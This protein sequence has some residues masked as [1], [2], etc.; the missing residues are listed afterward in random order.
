ME[1]EALTHWNEI[2]RAQLGGVIAIVFGLT[3]ALLAFCGSLLTEDAVTFGGERTVWFLIAVVFFIMSLIGGVIVTITRLQDARLTAR[4]VGKRNDP[5]AKEEVKTLRCC[6]RCLG[7]WTWRL[8]YF[9]LGMFSIGAA[10]L[11]FALWYI[12]YPKLFP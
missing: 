7:S 8:I 10:F 11:L 12:F 5:S 3:T 2:R 9:Q 4:I 6:A 1:D